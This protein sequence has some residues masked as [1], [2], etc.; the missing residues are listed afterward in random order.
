MTADLLPESVNGA[1]RG[2]T[3]SDLELVEPGCCVYTSEPDGDLLDH[4]IRGG[5]VVWI[6][7]GFDKDSGELWRRFVTASPS[8]RGIRWEHLDA[9]QVRQIMGPNSASIRGLIRKMATVV[10]LSKST[11]STDE[12]RCI[13]GQ[14]TLMKALGQ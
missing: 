10:A 1:R 2:V 7:T 11:F 14:V 3:R 5:I 12:A 4:Q 6:E 9:A 13:N 8:G